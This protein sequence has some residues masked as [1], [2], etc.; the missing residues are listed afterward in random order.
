MDDGIEEWIAWIVAAAG[1][2][3]VTDYLLRA[4]A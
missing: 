1:A 2:V 3:Y 4:Q